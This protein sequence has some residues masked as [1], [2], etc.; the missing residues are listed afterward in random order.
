MLTL[1]YRA[2]TTLLIYTLIAVTFLLRQWQMKQT[3]QNGVNELVK[4]TIHLG[5]KLS[6]KINSTQV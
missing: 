1:F 4:I 3:I 6:Q 2:M 5:A